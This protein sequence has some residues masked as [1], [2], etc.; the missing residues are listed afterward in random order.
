MFS[1]ARKPSAASGT[2]ISPVAQLVKG[3]RPARQPNARF[4]A[5]RSLKR[6]RIMKSV[7]RFRGPTATVAVGACLPIVAII[8][9][10]GG[11]SGIGHKLDLGHGREPE[12]RL[13]CRSSRGFVRWSLARP[14]D[15][16]NRRLDLCLSV[17]YASVD[18]VCRA[19]G[20]T[21]AFGQTVDECKL[22]LGCQQRRSFNI[23][24]INAVASTILCGLGKQLF[25]ERPPS[26]THLGIRNHDPCTPLYPVS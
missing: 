10:A 21:V 6:I 15:D 19:G 8:G 23:A 26:P 16:L 22:R 3:N 5:S 12:R 20:E 11:S 18:Q 2:S 17:M 13:L 14:D 9:L 25:P 7:Y 24:S 1:V 4:L